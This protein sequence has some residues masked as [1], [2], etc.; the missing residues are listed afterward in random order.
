M[1]TSDKII[2]RNLKNATLLKNS[3]PLCFDTKK[4]YDAWLEPEMIAKT[5]P[6]RHNICEDCT[7]SYKNRMISENRCI[8]AQIVLKN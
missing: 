1:K 7:Q 3:F 4:Q 2:E 6:I 5:S 8:N